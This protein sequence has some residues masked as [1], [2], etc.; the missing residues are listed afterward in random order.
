MT[1]QIPPTD[2]DDTEGHIFRQVSESERD[3]ADDVAG[4][5]S[6]R[7]TGVHD[8]V[9]DD[10]EGRRFPAGGTSPAGSEDEDDVTGHGLRP[11]DPKRM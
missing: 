3:E 9:T 11:T 1:E 10:V 2:P 8:P 4:H 5:L 7:P 6:P